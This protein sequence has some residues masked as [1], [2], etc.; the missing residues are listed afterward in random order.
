[1][2]GS[3]TAAKTIHRLKRR[4]I[5][6][7]AFQP[8]LAARE[9]EACVLRVAPAKSDL[10]PRALR[11]AGNRQPAIKADLAVFREQAGLAVLLAAQRTVVEG[12]LHACARVVV[13]AREVDHEFE[14]L[15][16]RRCR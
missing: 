13:P 11:G 15:R 10:Q 5:C 6:C 14:A 1:M 2:P 9:G 4:S 16:F 3:T 7:S 12:G 8:A